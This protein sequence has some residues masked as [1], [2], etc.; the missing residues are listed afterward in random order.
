VTNTPRCAIFYTV[1]RGMFPPAVFSAHSLKAQKH[2]NSFDTVIAVPENSIPLEWMEWAEKNVGLKV[3]EVSFHSLVRIERTPNPHLPTSTTFRYHF[4]HFASDYDR[5]I[6]LDAD[7]RVVGDIS[8]L[9]DLCLGDHSFAAVQDAIFVAGTD[10]H[11]VASAYFAGLGLDSS[12]RYLNSGMLVIDPTRWRQDRISQK[13]NEFMESNLDS[14]LFAD[15]SALNAVVRGSFQN[16][17]PVWNAL[18]PIWF[19]GRL[20]EF[21]SPALFHYVGSMKPWKPLQWRYTEARDYR[22]YQD[23]FR[24][25]PWSNFINS[26]F[27]VRDL[28]HYVR[29]RRRRILRRLRGRPPLA[30]WPADQV[31]RYVAHLCHTDFADVNQ[32]IVVRSGNTLSL[33]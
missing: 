26:F 11:S 6:Y 27:S 16:L 25:S 3:K 10:P 8:L 18:F 24:C 9:F 13:V 19:N 21:V 12:T 28:W 33:H 30:P 22:Y 5:L 29:Y 2:R 1:D 4:D 7:T 17:S 15:Q 31:A 32:G 14:C 20:S 23:F